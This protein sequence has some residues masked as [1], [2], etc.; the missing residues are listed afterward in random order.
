MNSG[1]GSAQ[2]T[3]YTAS[4]MLSGVHL[5]YDGRSWTPAFSL[6]QSPFLAVELL[7]PCMAFSLRGRLVNSSLDTQKRLS[8]SQ[9]TAAHLGALSA[10][11]TGLLV[12]R[13]PG[14]LVRNW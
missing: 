7:S 10:H 11:R 3:I 14:T 4:R 6:A 5:D 12:V 1:A 8:R 13:T 2:C 9:S